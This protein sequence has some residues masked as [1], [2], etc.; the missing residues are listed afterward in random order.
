MKSVLCSLLAVAFLIGCGG[1][2]TEKVDIQPGEAWLANYIGEQKIGY[3]VFLTERFEDGYRFDNLMRMEIAMADKVQK[4]KTHSVVTTEPDLT[5]RTFSFRIESQDRTMA[6]TGGAQGNEL[7]IKVE[8]DRPRVLKLEGPVYPMSALGLLAVSREPDSLYKFNVFDPAMMAITLVELTPVGWE[9][10]VIDGVEYRA[11]KTRSKLAQFEITSWV[12]EHGLTIREESP[13]DMTSIRTTPDKAVAGQTGGSL[14]LLK[15]FRVQVDTLVSDPGAVRRMKVELSGLA[16][17]DYELEYGYQRVLGTDPLVVEVSVPE[18]PDAPMELPI[19]GMDEFLG[20]TVAI[21]CDNPALAEQAR[22]VLGEPAD[23]VEASRKLTSWVFTALDKEPTASFPTALD[24]LKHM[25]GDCNEH[26]VFFAGLAR[27]AGIP[28]KVSVGLVYM[29][30]AFYYHAWNEVFLGEW[31]PVD[32][33][34][35]EFPAGA[36]RLKLSE[37]GLEQQTRI[38][39]VV[40]RLGMKILELE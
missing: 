35:G 11:L 14:D 34:F 6:A 10:L 3:S 4:L 33:T 12:D 25:K 31:V 36:L 38:L 1:A 17:N 21:Q 15:M 27:A 16:P 9:K 2:R 5:L 29:N 26:A 40:G 23:A 7:I 24:V 32:P 30:G 8:G 20:P 22:G 18:T 19:K 39:G 28:T 13:P 37:G